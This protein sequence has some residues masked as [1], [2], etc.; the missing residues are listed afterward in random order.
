MEDILEEIVG[1]IYDEY[2]K[3]EKK[4]EKIDDSTYICDGEMPIYEL[5]KILDIKIP[6]GD[7]D[8]LSGYL[9]ENLETIPNEKEKP[10]FKTEK[11]IYK[12]EKCKENKILKV[13]IK[14]K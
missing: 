12:V 4:Y 1:D 11:A 10:I 13:K 2:D 6:E 8:T 9:F 7:Y 3:I 5:E 14:K